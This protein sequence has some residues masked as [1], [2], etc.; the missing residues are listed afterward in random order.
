LINGLDF[1]GT[2]NA[3]ALPLI[4]LVELALGIWVGVTSHFIEPGLSR[5]FVLC[6]TPTDTALRPASRVYFFLKALVS[7]ILEHAR[8]PARRG[9]SQ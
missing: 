7:N 3:E 8:R 5:M 9:K 4:L 1:Y 2:S 6:P